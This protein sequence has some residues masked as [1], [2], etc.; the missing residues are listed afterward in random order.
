MRAAKLVS[1][2]LI[3]VRPTDTVDLALR[4]ADDNKLEHL[5]LVDN[6]HLVGVIA[7]DDLFN[8]DATLTIE[9]AN[10]PVKLVEVQEDMH[11]FEAIKLFGVTQLSV[12]PVKGVDGYLGSITKDTIL[13]AIEQ[14]SGVQT[15]GAT[16]ILEMNPRDY[17]LVQIAQIVEGNDARVLAT[18]IQAYPERD[19]IDVTLKLNTAN[20]GGLLQTFAR[21]NYFIKATYQE[22]N[23]DDIIQ[24]RYDELMNYINM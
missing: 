10:V 5:P 1:K 2:L 4:I 21:Y 15:A 8:V 19:K 20:I 16:V 14:T 7:E 13:E 12:L 22:N 24:K 6:D 17:S 9:Q 23:V 18:Q 11:Y 3:E